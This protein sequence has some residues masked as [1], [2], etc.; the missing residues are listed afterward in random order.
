MP[1]NNLNLILSLVLIV[2]VI[3]KNKKIK[4]YYSLK[5]FVKLATLSLFFAICVAYIDWR[6]SFLISVIAARSFLWL[7]F[8]YFL[9]HFNVKK[10]EI[11]EALKLYSILYILLV[12]L[13]KVSP[14]FN[15]LLR[16]VDYKGDLITD[17][18]FR[19]IEFVVLFFYFKVEQFFIN[20]KKEKFYY[21]WVLVL[22]ATIV[23]TE[24]R[25]TLF[26]VLIIVGYK[27]FTDKQ[28]KL[29]YKIIIMLLLVIPIYLLIEDLLAN[30]LEETFAQISDQDYN[31]NKAF[32]YLI[33]ELN[34]SW[35]SKI[36]GNGFASLNSSYGIVIANLKEQG[37][38][39]SDMGI[40]GLWTI[41]GL[42][43]V[44]AIGKYIYR[45]I[46]N[47]RVPLYLKMQA[48][49]II[50]GFLMYSFV[51]PQQIVFFILYFY[52][53]EHEIRYRNRKK[54]FLVHST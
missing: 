38:F 29:Y 30:L 43:I 7:S 53:A 10:T 6:Q 28:L 5:R 45:I 49:H 19:G 14:N 23:F 44:Y 2:M 46:V 36:F 21:I 13:V 41:Y 9:I 12:I 34:D 50:I 18:L 33:F 3:A 51:L 11:H 42:L 48:F 8:A 39:Q 20:N 40:L 17:T 25:T 27:M 37:I 32:N 26:S 15:F 22:F 52:L 24:N 54:T 16:G 35:Y 31:R 1:H 4:G 47:I